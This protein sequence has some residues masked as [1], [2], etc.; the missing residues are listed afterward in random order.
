M[1]SAAVANTAAFITIFAFVVIIAGA[2][3]K[4]SRWAMQEIGLR[5][6]DRLLGAAF[7]LVRGIVVV[8][9]LVMAAATFLPQ[10][11][12]LETSELSRYFLL[13]AKTASWIAP[14]DVRQRFKDGVAYVRKTRMEGLGP[15]AGGLPTKAEKQGSSREASKPQ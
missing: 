4:I 8:T 13:S 3:G 9:V 10:S 6:I 14:S 15:S 12:W 1:K 11:K 5:W 7:G 2:A